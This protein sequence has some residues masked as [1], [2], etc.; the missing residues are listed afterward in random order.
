M[1]LEFRQACYNGYF[2][3]Q[4]GAI[5]PEL[6][7]CI[8]AALAFVG[9]CLWLRERRLERLT[10]TDRAEVYRRVASLSEKLEAVS[11]DLDVLSETVRVHDQ[12]IAN[13]STEWA[14]FM[15]KIKSEQITTLGAMR[16][17]RR[18]VSG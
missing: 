12:A 7:I 16:D 17:Y 9:Y 14:Q 15:V 3:T 11:H 18:N 4:Y 5:M 8:P 2:G 6:T 10:A 13:Q 1:S